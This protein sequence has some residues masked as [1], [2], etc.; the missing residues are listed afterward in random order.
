M[1]NGHWP[2]TDSE[3]IM[4][5]TFNVPAHRAETLTARI[6]KLAKKAKRYGNADIQFTI[7]KPFMQDIVQGGKT[8]AIELVTV[9]VAGDAPKFGDYTFAAKVEL[10]GEE[11]IVHN[12]AN[13]ELDARFRTM[14]NECDHCGHHRNR[15]N[16]YVFVDANGKQM[17]VGQTCL[18]DFTGCDNPEEIV[19]RATIIG[20]LAAICEEEE[21]E[22][23]G[24]AG[25][26]IFSAM[27]ILESAAANIRQYG[28]ISKAKAME[29]ET[30][31]T[32]QYV[33]NDLI[34][35]KGQWVAVE[36][37]DADKALAQ[38]TMDYFRAGN[39]FD[40]NYLD[41]IRVILK[42]DIV[43]YRH[44]ALVASGVQHIIR[45]MGQIVAN[46]AKAIVS[47]YIGNEGDKL[48]D[49]AVIFEKE[50]FIG[51][52]QFGDKYLYCFQHNGNS[53][54]WFTDKRD[55]VIGN[56]YTMSA[57]IKELKEYNGIKQTIVTR[58]KIK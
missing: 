48:K 2:L 26:Y 25:E 28:W 30:M 11:N 42:S 34:K 12:V 44:L 53:V 40:N 49:I 7:T 9:T 45:E 37:C 15:N 39:Q 47:D 32:A 43:A 17:A 21:K 33:I 4:F 36:I 3:T 22:Y 52:T 18:R 13:I 56:A 55:Y 38:S 8:F 27:A 14:K 29:L 50:I 23:W 19:N 51:T 41:N 54:N 1:S 35:I 10:I 57:T 6:A 24:G 31:P 16:V 5:A 58:A 46:K 20:D